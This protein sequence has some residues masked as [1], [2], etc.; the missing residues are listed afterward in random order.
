MGNLRPARKRSVVLPASLLALVVTAGAGLAGCASNEEPGTVKAERERRSSGAAVGPKTD[1]QA[2]Y[3]AFAAGRY[4]EALAAAD[5]H[6]AA[7]PGGGRGTAEALYL[8]GRVHEQRAE[9]AA[10]AQNAAAA[11][12]HLQAARDAYTR[13]LAA[14]PAPALEAHILMGRANVAHFQD[15]YTLAAAQWATALQKIDALPASEQAQ[16]QE[17]RPWALYRLGL[18]QQRLGR[19]AEA[20]TTFARVQQQFPGTE[21]ARRAAAHQGARAFHVQVGTYTDPANAS[22]AA[23]ALKAEGYAP[24]TT[25]DPAGRQ[26]VRVGPIPTYEQAKAM[27]KVLAARYPGALIVP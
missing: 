16:L 3:A 1:L 26:V 13:A 19:F 15:D 27:R 25:P 9:R 17:S 7:R 21:P 5:Q 8:K 2:G 20:D 18:S 10:A 12:T 22:A 6:L 4:D 24:Q 23:G 11:A 14:S